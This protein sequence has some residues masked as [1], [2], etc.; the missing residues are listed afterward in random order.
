MHHFHRAA[1]TCIPCGMH[2]LPR[3]SSIADVVL[4]LYKNAKPG[5]LVSHIWLQAPQT[6]RHKM[7]QKWKKAK[8]TVSTIVMDICKLRLYVRHHLT[9]LIA[10]LGK[11]LSFLA[12]MKSSSHSQVEYESQAV[13]SHA[14][15]GVWPVQYDMQRH[16][17]Q[18]SPSDPVLCTVCAATCGQ[19][20]GEHMLH[21]G[22]HLEQNWWRL[23]HHQDWSRF[24]HCA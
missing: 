13:H 21:P 22:H 12:Q 24:C 16:T 23:R 17:L 18:M 8:M 14:K 7:K 9:S 11:T 3:H 4:K 2:Q 15:A 5:C 19:L 20:T 10:S 1:H 6:V